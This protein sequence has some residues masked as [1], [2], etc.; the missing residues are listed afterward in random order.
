MNIRKLIKNNKGLS[1]VEGV[2]A[3]GLITFVGYT[4]LNQMNNQN[5]TL[6]TIVNTS[7]SRSVVNSLIEAVSEDVSFYQIQYNGNEGQLREKQVPMRW[8]YDGKIYKPEE[9]KTCV[10]KMGV[11]IT[12]VPQYRGFYKLT[13]RISHPS[14]KEDRILTKLVMN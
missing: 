14:F 11:K 7:M 12:P 9:C 13:I 10:G 1:L 4:G 5:R 6:N 3:T 2:I 8:D